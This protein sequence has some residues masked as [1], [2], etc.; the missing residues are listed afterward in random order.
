LDLTVVD[1]TGAEDLSKGVYCPKFELTNFPS[2]L[3]EEL[4][5]VNDLKEHKGVSIKI[6]GV[7][8]DDCKWY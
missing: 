4:A 8:L 7:A 2:Q 1:I 3:K 6:N 5:L